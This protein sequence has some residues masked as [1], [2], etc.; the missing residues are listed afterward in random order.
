MNILLNFTS[1]EL[2]PHTMNKYILIFLFVNCTLPAFNQ[3]I[4]GTVL[5]QQ[6]GDTIG[7]AS[8]YFS[9]TFV[10]TT[11]NLEGY[12]ELDVSDYATRPLT[13]SAVG[14]YSSSLGEFSSREHFLVDLK[15]KVYD[16]EEISIT[17]N[18]LTRARKANLKLFRKEFLGESSNARNCNIM[19]EE[20][21][22]F[23]YGTDSDTLRAYASKP[24]LVHNGALG[25]FVTYYLDQFEYQRKRHITSFRGDIRFDEDL[26]RSSSGNPEYEKSRKVAYH[27]SCM[28]FFRSLWNEDFDLT[29][30]EV[31]NSNDELLEWSDLV[32]PSVE[33]KKILY[34]REGLDI[35]FRSEWSNITFLKQ[36]VLFEQNG[37]WDPMAILWNGEMADDR[38]GDSIYQ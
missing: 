36:K 22:T 25:Y 23:N 32:F 5:D 35:Y 29:I 27:G 7:Y 21:I 31:K 15:P 16:I 9:G 4:S 33:S 12:F 3:V 13:I 26:T 14:Y 18:S 38:I 20:D 37:F 34:Y 10:G 24:I 11:T 1:F 30:F 6:T 19:N 28:H 17:T 8:V 2:S